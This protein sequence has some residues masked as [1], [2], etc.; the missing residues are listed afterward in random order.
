MEAPLTSPVS[1]PA[2]LLCANFRL[3]ASRSLSCFK[4]LKV[5]FQVFSR[6]RFSQPQALALLKVCACELLPW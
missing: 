5:L 1:A 6:L 2:V 4:Y 3:G